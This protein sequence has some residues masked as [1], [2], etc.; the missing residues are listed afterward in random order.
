MPFATERMGNR[1]QFKGQHDL[2][3][4]FGGIYR[5]RGEV[6]PSRFS[7]TY[8]SR[9]DTGVF[10]LRRVVE[11]RMA[12]NCFPTAKKNGKSDGAI[13]SQPKSD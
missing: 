13:D 1:L 11:P 8:D 9:Y 5:Y 7:A 4:L 3:P 10:D 2:G 12:A 6:T